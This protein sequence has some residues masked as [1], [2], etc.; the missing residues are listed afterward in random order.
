LASKLTGVAGSSAYFNGSV[1]AYSYQLKEQLLGVNP[2][3]LLDFGA[4]SEQTI[5]EMAINCQK[6]LGTNI[7]IATSG[8][9]GPGGGTDDKPVGTVWTAICIDGKVFTKKLQLGG[10]RAENIY[11]T[12]LLT[13]AFLRQLLIK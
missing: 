12:T 1:V 7:A 10:T 11:N 4:V 9:A 6:I 8:I 13:L 2:Q 5:S 3:T